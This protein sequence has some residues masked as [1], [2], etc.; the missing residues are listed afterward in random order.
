MKMA[1]YNLFE[2]FFHVRYFNSTCYKIRFPLTSLKSFT[3]NCFCSQGISTEG[4]C[5][6][7][8]STGCLRAFYV[9]LVPL[10]YILTIPPHSTYV[11]VICF[12][13]FKKIEGPQH[14]SSAF[15]PALG[16]LNQRYLRLEG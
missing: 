1:G 8:V 15:L 12:I 11:I 7:V 3:L 6:L 5:S 13:L 14:I 2:N 9:I 4:K 16:R 10:E